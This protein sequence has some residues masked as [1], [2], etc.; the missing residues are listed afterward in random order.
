MKL[1][2][3]KAKGSSFE[4]HIGTKLSLWLSNNERKDLVCRTVGSGAQFTFSKGSGNPGDLMGQHPIA[5]KFFENY[6]CECKFWR[7][8]EI[9]KFLEKEGDLYRALRKVQREAESQS[10]QWILIA[11]QNHR[12]ILLFLPTQSMLNST[13]KIGQL[14]FH[15]IFSGTVYMFEFE[16]FLSVIQPEDLT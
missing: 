1:G 2:A 10:K 12:K 11:K 4:R 15:V 3:G 16:N 13:Q 8:L 5:F 6:A 14:N 7:N 9:I